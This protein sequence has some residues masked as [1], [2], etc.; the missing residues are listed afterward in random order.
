MKSI[1]PIFILLLFAAN[2]LC[3]TTYIGQNIER[4]TKWSKANSPYIITIDIEILA[5]AIVE[6]EAGVEVRFAKETRLIVSGGI[7]AKGTKSQKISFSGVENGAWN[8][9]LFLKECNDYNEKTGEGVRFDYCSFIGTG[10]TPAQLIRSKGCNIS[11][12]NSNIEG[13]YT[14]IQME[15][16][17]EI[18][19]VGSSFKNCNRVINVQNTSMV[20]MTNNTMA[21][22]NSLILGGTTVLKN[23]ILKDFTGK[24]RHSGIVVWMLGGGVVDIQG[25]QFLNFEDYAIKLYKTTNRSSFLIRENDFKNNKSNL[26][27]S[28]KYYNKGRSVIEN[29]NFNSCEK[30][31]IV[32]FAPCSEEKELQTIKIGANYWG[33]LS[34]AEMKT[35][36]FDHHQDTN[37]TAM[38]ECAP[39]LKKIFKK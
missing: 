21:A 10:T 12:T 23:N 3:A 34:E 38:V 36:I 11:I 17:A 37:I 20:T 25:N 28:C 14:A 18:W 1:Y 32:L 39:P 5:T 27:L 6:I 33:K 22:C 8:G 26:H 31:N 9:F 30:Y 24:G 7:V 29:N 15:R 2:N 13:C 16:Q 35:T 4:N 19:V